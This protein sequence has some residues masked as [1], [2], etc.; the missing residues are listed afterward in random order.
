MKR[1]ESSMEIRK[2]RELSPEIYPAFKPN[3]QSNRLFEARKLTKLKRIFEVL[4]GDGDGLISGDRME[5]DKLPDMAYEILKPVL[6]D[7][8]EEEK[9]VDFEGFI[10]ECGK[11]MK[12]LTITEKADI[13]G[14]NKKAS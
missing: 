6:L 1:P 5:I 3:E 4:D 9:E 7:I 14:S 12:K 8:T 11:L 13:F 2:P 10:K